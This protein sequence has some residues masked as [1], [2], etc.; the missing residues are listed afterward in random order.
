MKI[1]LCDSNSI[2]SYGF[3]TD[4]SGIDLTRFKKNPVMLYNHNPEMVIGKWE[5]ITADGL[6][7]TA[8]PVFD[9]DDVFAA[10][11]ARK[12][13]DGFIKGCSMGLMIKSMTKSKGIDTA[14]ESVL[15]EASIVSIPADENALVVYADESKKKKLSINEFNKLY[16]QMENQDITS[17]KAQL[18]EKDTQNAA[19]KAQVDEL[20]KELAE[21]DFVEAENAALTAVQEGKI[22]EDIKGDIIA[23]YLE[24]KERTAKLLS[25]LNPKQ[26]ETPALSLS[27]MVKK[28]GETVK[29]DWDSLDKSGELARL[30]QINPEE[31]RRLYFEKFGKE[32]V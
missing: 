14:S 4:V 13:E 2:N 12:V 28:D 5:N 3:R 19:L 9:L 7:L 18:E 16:Y 11:I 24:N 1:V 8:E 30:K 26:P 31:F 10:E 23:M 22:P 15:L 6:Q 29:R 20:Q 27:A 32:Y 21:R 17:L 25:V